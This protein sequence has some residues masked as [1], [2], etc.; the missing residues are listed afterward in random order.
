MS[1][2]S[3]KVAGLDAEWPP[4]R[5]LRQLTMRVFLRSKKT[6]LYCAGSNER[7]ATAT[8]ALPFTSVAHA[9][10]F[11]FTEKVPEAEIV[12]RYDL[13]EEDVAVPLLADWCDL[14][15]PTSAAG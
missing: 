3:D 11:G 14:R 2:R 15:E 12:V 8:Q 6:R 9:A 1:D 13:L 10:E 4:P 5:D 7:A